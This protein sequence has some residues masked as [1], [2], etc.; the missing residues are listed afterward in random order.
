MS[1]T[2]V[3]A[4][5]TLVAC[6]GQQRGTTPSSTPTPAPTTPRVTPPVGP[7]ITLETTASN[8]RS[9]AMLR[10]F[11]P[12]QVWKQ[13]PAVYE[14]LGIP[15]TRLDSAQHVI[16]NEGLKLRRRLKDVPLSRLLDCGGGMGMSNA[17]SY[18]VYLT[19]MTRLRPAADGGTQ[20]ET[21]VDASAKPVAFNTSASVACT[22]TGGL[23]RRL[24]ERLTERVKGGS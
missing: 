6:A 23:E 24:H 1:R 17:D 20:V 12:D 5:L 15:I 16:G 22:S 2:P 14:E 11:Y 9:T 7:T 10:G 8:S 18:E 3:I 19:V 4:V 21:V 13:L